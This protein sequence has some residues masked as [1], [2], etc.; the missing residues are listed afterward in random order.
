MFQRV[1][2]PLW[3]IHLCQLTWRQSKVNLVHDEHIIAM[4]F[5]H[6]SQQALHEV[7]LC[8]CVF[9]CIGTIWWALSV[10]ADGLPPHRNQTLF[11]VFTR[12][13]NSSGLDWHHNAVRV[14]REG[15]EDES[16]IT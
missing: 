8:V 10:N 6:I 9:V 3:L 15:S 11:T 14:S 16:P 13:D 1:K 7:C 2:L 12:V 5:S 4:V